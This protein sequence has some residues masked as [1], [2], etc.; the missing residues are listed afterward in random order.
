MWLGQKQAWSSSVS[1]LET[2]ML[3][4]FFLQQRIQRLITPALDTDLFLLSSSHFESEV[5]SF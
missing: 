5:E 1:S 4:M 3:V 2:L